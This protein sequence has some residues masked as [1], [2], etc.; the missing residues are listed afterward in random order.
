MISYDNLN[1]LNFKHTL[2]HASYTHVI[3]PKLKSTKR[4][5]QTQFGFHIDLINA[6]QNSLEIQRYSY[7]YSQFSR[8][9]YHIDLQNAL[10][11]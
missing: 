3:M 4:S 5:H 11:L 9:G 1:I 2:R 10:A 6:I 7:K 8:F